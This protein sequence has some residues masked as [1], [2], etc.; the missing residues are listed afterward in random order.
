M[1]TSTRTQSQASSPSRSSDS[2]ESGAP[3]TVH[4]A[5]PRYGTVIPEG[6]FVGNSDTITQTQSQASSPSRSSGSPEPS[7]PLTVHHAPRYGTVI[8]N[9]IFV[10][11]IDTRT[12]EGD[13][14]RF[15]SHY[16]V[17]KEVKIVIDR[18]GVSKGYGFVTF[19]TQEDAHKI[20]HEAGR[21]SI[22]DKTLN[23][24]QAIRRQHTGMLCGLVSQGPS[25]PLAPAPSCNTHYLTT[26]TGYPYTYH[27]G[28]AYFHTP[29][30]HAHTHWP[31]HPVSAASPAM[32]APSVYPQHAHY[33]NNYQTAGQYV[34]PHQW[35]GVVPHPPQPPV[36]SSPV[37]Y[38]QSGDLHHYHPVEVAAVTDV[39]CGQ[40][41]APLHD[42]AMAEM[43][44]MVH[45]S[46][47]HLYF[48]SPAATAAILMHRD[49]IKEHSK[50]YSGRRGLSPSL[51]N[52]CGRYNNAHHLHNGHAH[53]ETAEYPAPHTTTELQ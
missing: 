6:I 11:N 33:H 51:R 1:D 19:E 49:S 18:A 41:T 42:A 48:P 13:L 12:N 23:I 28:V 3:L 16:G 5:P 32:T 31:S 21:L 47:Q 44:V 22:R 45:A 4:H 2:P 39:A 43:D 34:T 9:R 53:T 38:L 46:F 37:V 15:F 50:F 24:G 36:S 14:R 10:G 25:A 27:N 8:P 26:S 40:P 30:A 52:R 29:D 20:L 35:T 7:A 17:V